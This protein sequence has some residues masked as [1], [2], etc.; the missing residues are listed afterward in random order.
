MEE[1]WTSLKLFRRGEF[2]K[3]THEQVNYPGKSEDRFVLSK[4]G[5]LYYLGRRRESREMLDEDLKLRL[6]VSTT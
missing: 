3:L 1:K 5:L 2:D 6:V 4:D